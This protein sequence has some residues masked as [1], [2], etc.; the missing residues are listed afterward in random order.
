[1][2]SLGKALKSYESLFA[3]RGFHKQASRDRGPLFVSLSGKYVSYD[4]ILGGDLRCFLGIA[5]ANGVTSPEI[6][7]E[8][9][10]W[11]IALGDTLDAAVEA[12]WQYMLNPGFLFLNAPLDLTPTQWR[13]RFNLLVRDN[14]IRTLVVS[15]PTDWEI[16]QVVIR[17]KRSIPEYSS[18]S[19]LELHNRLKQKSQITILS[20]P[21]ADALE[22]K[23]ALE[24]QGFLVSVLPA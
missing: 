6:E 13:E 23:I 22:L 18:M 24:T 3:E 11:N 19:G 17:I 7:A 10:W 20:K 9:P 21:L 2:D 1:M 5:V 12:S 14:R 4:R 16:N 8:S 15:W